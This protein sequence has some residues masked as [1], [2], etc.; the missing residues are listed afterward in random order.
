[1]FSRPRPF[2]IVHVSSAHPWTDNRIHTRAA[3]TAARAGYR[4]ALVAV[5]A[6]RGERPDVDWDAPEEQTGVWVRRLPRRRRAARLLVSTVQAVRAALSSRAQVVHLHDPELVW[7]IPVLRLARRRVVYDAHEDLPVQVAGKEYLGHLRGAAARVAHAVVALARHADVVVA[8]TPSVARRF[9]A[10][11]T[12]VV[13]NLP[14]LR[15]T[16]ALLADP[17]DRPPVAVYLG[18]MSHDRGLDVI[19][20]V[21]ASPGLPSGWCLRTAGPID[22]AVDRRAFD[23]LCSSGRINHSGVLP[24]DRARDLLQGARVGLLPLLPT[25]A[26]AQSIPTKL[27]EYLAAGLA[28]IATDIPSWRELL[29]GVDCVT[30]VPAGDPDAVISALQRYAGRPD[31]LDAHARAGRAAVAEHFRWDREAPELLR[32]YRQLFGAAPSDGVSPFTGLDL[33]DS[34]RNV[35][36][37]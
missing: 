27:F 14:V 36:Y 4:T 19:S 11:R 6:T 12:T 25:P 18:A 9:P 2:D 22:G 26:Y 23:A 37:K 21:A 20:A 5:V 15:A 29:A 32:V 35:V 7:A 30:W 10:D 8:A 3:A 17:S 16:D 34:N 28:V 24:P 33:D 31:L 13:R 1:M